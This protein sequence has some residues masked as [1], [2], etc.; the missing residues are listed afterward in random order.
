MNV[1]KRYQKGFTLVELLVVIAIIA[2]LLSMLMP[3]LGRV[4]NQAKQVLCMS[5]AR[6]FGLASMAYGLDFKD[7]AI[8][9]RWANGGNWIDMNTWYSNLTPYMDAS[10]K[11]R[12]DV[13][14]IPT[15]EARRYNEIWNKMRCPAEKERQSKF[16]SSSQGVSIQTYAYHYAANANALFSK[17]YGLF[18]WYTGESRKL[19][20][21]KNA[22]GMLMFT[23]MRDNEYTYS[24]NYYYC[25][26]NRQQWDP[27]WFIPD[28]HPSGFCT[29]FVDGHGDIVKSE[30]IR[31]AKREYIT[32]NIWRAK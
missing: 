28:R 30:I 8:A 9:G 21:V 11:W 13:W 6:Q 3:A 20:S 1:T 4:R 23:D 10:K 26:S 32:D 18:N 16:S 12:N 27:E 19:S 2:L 14:S 5:Y 31:D 29:T 25:V 22:S 7:K 17:G 24:G 15:T